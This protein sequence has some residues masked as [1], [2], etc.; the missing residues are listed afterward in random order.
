MGGVR[1]AISV[2]GMVRY[3]TEKV[4]WFLPTLAPL[5]AR[6]GESAD[7]AV[8][9]R[10]TG[11]L[12]AQAAGT[13][14]RAPGP[15]S[16]RADAR[17]HR[18]GLEVQVQVRSPAAGSWRSQGSWEK[19]TCDGE[20]HQEEPL[21]VVE[22]VALHSEGA[23]A[24]LWGAPGG[25]PKGND[26]SLLNASQRAPGG[27]EGAGPRP[28]WVA[29]TLAF[30]LIFT[31]VVDVLGNLLVILSVYRNKKLRN[32]GRGSRGRAAHY[33]HP[34]AASPLSVPF[35]EHSPLRCRQLAFSKKGDLSFFPPEREVRQF[36][37]PLTCLCKFCFCF[38]FF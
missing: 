12:L 16:L 11:A 9:A 4:P 20:W 19:S 6:P 37:F 35:A 8:Q 29:C 25:T 36:T 33:V 15:R 27:G 28:S 23:M 26:S 10:R 32:A 3:L 24:G 18:A 31:I 2:P 7:G 5:G 38:F 17:C 30:I 13:A 21:A 14:P 22:W 1:E 34:A